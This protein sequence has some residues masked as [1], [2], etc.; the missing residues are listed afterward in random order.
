M[1]INTFPKQLEEHKSKNVEHA[2]KNVVVKALKL[3][4]TNMMERFF[5]VTEAISKLL[6]V[7]TSLS[8]QSE[9]FNNLL[10]V[11][12]VC[13]NQTYLCSYYSRNQTYCN[14]MLQFVRLNLIYLS[15][16]SD[17]LLPMVSLS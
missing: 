13:K 7:L 16:L 14:L 12:R 8:D 3:T 15:V 10:L 1:E 9:V 11:L 5:M 2:F 4:H 6:H 17:I